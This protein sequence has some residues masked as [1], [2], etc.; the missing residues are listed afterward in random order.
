M[1]PLLLHVWL[2]IK[3]PNGLQEK[4]IE[5]EGAEGSLHLLIAG[6]DLE[7]FFFV[8]E[9]LEFDFD[10]NWIEAFGFL[11]ADVFESLLHDFVASLVPELGSG[12]PD[13]P[14]LII[15]IVDGE[16]RRI[17]ESLMLDA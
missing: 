11:L 10:I 7:T 3:N 16:V 4:V 13:K 1:G 6:I 12:I 2:G 14:L 17:I 5:I 8:F 15:L 9:G